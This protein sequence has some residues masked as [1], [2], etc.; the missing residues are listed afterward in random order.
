M[1]GIINVVYSI[2]VL[3]LALAGVAFLVTL[4]EDGDRASRW[5]L[6][7]NLLAVAVFLVAMV[8]SLLLAA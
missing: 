2:A 8:A 6:W 4:S 3:L 7:S 1:A 5:S